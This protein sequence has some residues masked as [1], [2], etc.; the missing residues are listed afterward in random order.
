MVRVFIPPVSHGV[1]SGAVPGVT[2]TVLCTLCPQPAAPQGLPSTHEAGSGYRIQLEAQASA[3][4]TATRRRPHHPPVRVLPHI[5]R[6]D[7]CFGQ[8]LV[9]ASCPC[10]ASRHIEPEALARLVGWSR[11]P[12]D[13]GGASALLAVREVGRGG[14]AL[15][16]A[17]ASDRLRVI[18]QSKHGVTYP[19]R[20]SEQSGNRHHGQL[21]RDFDGRHIGLVVQE[22]R[23]QPELLHG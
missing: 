13:P 10:G 5:N 23:G 19:S 6:L 11:D 21:L 22:F 7:D 16:G 4:W 15:L 12:R 1:G 14:A 8:F 3:D 18:F 2:H 17:F 9:R 20:I